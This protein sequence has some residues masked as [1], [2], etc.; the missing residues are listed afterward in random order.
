[1]QTMSSKRM[2]YQAAAGADTRCLYQC[3]AME[4]ENLLLACFRAKYGERIMRELAMPL[5]LDFRAV[6]ARRRVCMVSRGCDCD[7]C[8]TEGA[9]LADTIVRHTVLFSLS[10]DR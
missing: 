4:T 3:L 10:S 2:A 8:Q 5:T 7:R 9:T 1:M 6:A